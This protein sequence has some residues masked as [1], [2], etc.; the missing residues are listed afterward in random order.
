MDFYAAI[1]ESPSAIRWKFEKL[2]KEHGSLMPLENVIFTPI[3]QSQSSIDTLREMKK[4]YNTNIMFDSGGY[5]VQVGNVGFDELHSYLQNFY[6]KNQWGDRYVLPDNVPT[7]EDEPKD[8]DRKVKETVSASRTLHKRLPEYVKD[9]SIPVVQG[10]EKK[11]IQHCVESY[12]DISK[13]ESLGFGSFQTAGKKNGVNMI[14]K[15]VIDNIKFLNRLLGKRND[16]VHAFGVGGPTSIPLIY[17]LGFDT[18]DSSSWLKSAAYGNVFFPF[19]SRLNVTHRKSRSGGILKREDL[20]QIKSETN[21]SCVFCNS[22][23]RLQNRENRILHNLIVTREVAKRV[24]NMEKDKILE[25]MNHKS[26]YYKL[27]Q[28]M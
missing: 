1:S 19:T 28:G 9:R 6:R 23:K 3:S 21:H 20:D 24:E 14:N 11:H 7:G 25:R 10:H 27:Y 16:K 26:T 22:I 18:F 2:E 17:E 8:V 5:E 15:S 4:T 13:K 12:K